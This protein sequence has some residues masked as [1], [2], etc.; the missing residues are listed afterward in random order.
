MQA[1]WLPYRLCC[2]L[3]CGILV[4]QPGSEPET[5][6]LTGTFF[7]TGPPGKSQCGSCI[8]NLKNSRNVFKRSCPICHSNQQCMRYLV[9]SPYFDIVCCFK[10]FSQMWDQ[11][12]ATSSSWIKIW[13]SC[14]V[15]VNHFLLF[16]A[17]LCYCGRAK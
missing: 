6:A 3:A 9:L 16:V 12:S 5:P 17:A 4:P 1:H 13:Y 2:P 15:F 10:S 7:T 8:F 11:G 14:P